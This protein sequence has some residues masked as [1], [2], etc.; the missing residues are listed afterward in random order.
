MQTTVVAPDCYNAG[1]T[2]HYCPDC[3]ETFKFDGDPAL[4]H[5]NMQTTVVAPDC[6]NAGYTEYYCPD[7][8]ETFKYDGDPALNHANMETTVVAPGCY[9]E[10]YTLYSCPDCGE[11]FKHD[12]QPALNHPNIQTTVVAP[13][14]Y[15]AGYTEYYCPDCK[16]TF[17]HE[18]DPATGHNFEDGAC[19]ECGEEDPDYVAPEQP[20][21]EECKA[22]LAHKFLKPGQKCALCD[23]VGAAEEPEAPVEPEQPEEEEC[24]AVLAH[25]FLKPGQKCA[26]CDFVGAAEEPEVPVEP[27]QPEEEECKAVLAHKFLKPGQKC[28]LC[29]FVGAAEEPEVPVE[30]EQPEEEEC[31]AI[32]AH[33]FLKPGQKCALCDFVGA[34]EEPEAPVEPEQPEEPA[35]VCTK[36]VYLPG[37]EV[38][39][40]V[41]CPECKIEAKEEHNFANNNV[42]ICGLI[43]PET[44]V[45]E[46][47][48]AHVCTKKV[49]L[50][51][52]E[53][54]HVVQCPECKF[55]AKEAHN[56]TDGVCIC[57]YKTP[58]ES[59]PVEPEQPEEDEKC[60]G[61]WHDI[62][63]N[64]GYVSPCPDCGE[65]DAK[66]DTDD[67][68]P[69]HKC[70]AETK[71]VANKDGLSHSILC[72]V[73][74]EFWK[75]EAH[76]WKDGACTKCCAESPF[77]TAPV[78]PVHKHE[79]ISLVEG[80]WFCKNCGKFT[81]NNPFADEEHK[82]FAETKAVANKDGLSHSIV[83][84]EC[85][86]FWKN[87]AHD[88]EDGVCTACGYESPFGTAPEQPE[89]GCTFGQHDQMIELG[90]ICPICGECGHTFVDGVCKW[91][92]AEEE[93]EAPV[94]PK[95][96][97]CLKPETCSGERLLET[98]RNGKLE[99]VWACGKLTFED[100]PVV[101]KHPGCLK[102]A[103]CT[104][105][106]LL[107]TERNGKLEVVWACGKLTFEDIPVVEK[108]PGCL[109]PETCSGEPLD[110]FEKNG[111]LEVV[112]PCGKL[113]FEDLPEEEKKCTFGQHDQ[114]I[115][116]GTKC[117]ICGEWGKVEEEQPDAD[118]DP[119]AHKC[120][121]ETKAV[122]NKD[123]LSHE[124]R[125]AECDKRWKTEAHNWE[126]GVC[127]DCGFETPF[128]TAPD[129]HKCMAET[130]AVANK[131]G[132]SHEIRCAECDKRWK[133][134]AHNW[135][136]GVCVDCGFETP[137]STAPEKPA[138]EHDWFTFGIMTKLGEEWFCKK[139]GKVE[140][141]E[142]AHVHEY[143]IEKIVD[144][145]CTEDGYKTGVCACGEEAPFKAVIKAT[146][147]DWFTFGIMTK[148][149]EEWFCKKCGKVEYR[150]VAHVHEYTIEKI[151]DATCTED[152]YKTG[153]CACGEEAPFKAVIKAT[154]HDWFTFGIMTKLGEEWFCKKCGK[155]EY[156]EVEP[157][158]EP[159][160]KP[161]VVAP[162]V[163]Y[164]T[165][166]ALA[167]FGPK[168]SE[169]GAEGSDRVAVI[170]VKDGEFALDV[171]THSYAIA[172]LKGE[173][174][175]GKL[176]AEVKAYNDDIR[177][178][179]VE[180][181]VYTSVEA[182]TADEGVV[183]G[184]EALDL[185]GATIVIIEVNGSVAFNLNDDDVKTV[186]FNNKALAAMAELVK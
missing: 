37:D 24:K 177:L 49:Y 123:G 39:H 43:N 120:M 155:V 140:Y 126:D 104:G 105:E 179:N 65:D 47:E 57:G 158:V 171:I 180:I 55:E 133:T 138:H 148:L 53:V 66:F 33:K 108:H 91:C 6:Y 35:H 132:L 116:L 75:N 22:V 7:C 20:E 87:E 67:E 92:K 3:K 76:E 150:E 131:D 41:Q 110:K 94:E 109:K 128:S 26:L 34:A 52:D 154:G 60:T 56:Y 182:Y 59:K 13:D 134:E 173:I 115:A 163:N 144:A 160:E 117:P 168:A 79:W 183:L 124:I 106:R 93:V 83:C 40:V 85:G 68:E 174:A 143:T 15:N 130:K 30:P 2:E 172:T 48:P 44:D 11:S 72:A 8:K 86:E 54:T 80:E 151:V 10:G 90:C 181:V 89:E 152:G 125:C 63:V 156:R 71:V 32:L 81:L 51:G 159:D 164:L 137:F 141:R 147:H 96:P 162:V 185:A 139:C 169:I 166:G 16:E 170:E 114:L 14:C 23:F 27:E 97:G 127:V 88:W 176:T 1:Y 135:E 28:A 122:A 25:K 4:N 70:F 107:E 161:E 64:D 12:V 42:C 74:G 82:C 178:K 101:E 77:E 146:G 46:E 18:G 31:K 62:L 36:K 58:F 84:A 98:E 5:P 153:V 142:V 175:E 50:P 19:T 111:K 167:V 165:N 119:N 99:V 112:W 95:H 103:T 69:A 145:T 45:E 61:K 184:E 113:T 118:V 157:E 136:D 9:T 21:E 38:T 17:K 121:A 78:K 100:I 102:P 73:C 129:V 186:S 29:D 149:G